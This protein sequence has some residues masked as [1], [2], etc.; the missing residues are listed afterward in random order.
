MVIMSI[1]GIA[2]VAVLS[3]IGLMTIIV[4]VSDKNAD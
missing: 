3:F 2:T 1:I 4:A